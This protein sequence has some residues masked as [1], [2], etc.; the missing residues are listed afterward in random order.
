MSGLFSKAVFGSKEIF[1]DD[2]WDAFE[3]RTSRYTKKFIEE[4]KKLC[5]TYT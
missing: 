3:K 5:M 1:V 4:R 2:I